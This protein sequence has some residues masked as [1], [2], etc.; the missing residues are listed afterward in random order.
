MKSRVIRLA[1]TWPPVRLKHPFM[2]LPM[3]KGDK[4]MGKLAAKISAVMK[5]CNYVEK[6]EQIRS[7]AINMQPVQ[8]SW[9]K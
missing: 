7:M 3:K 8:M 6:M 4:T 1:S 5:D 9:Q 2:M